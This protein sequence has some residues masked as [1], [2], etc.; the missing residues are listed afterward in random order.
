EL[1]DE[2]KAKGF[3]VT[4]GG[5]EQSHSTGGGDQCNHAM[6]A[7]RPAGDAGWYCMSGDAPSAQG[8]NDKKVRAFLVACRL[9]DAPRPTTAAARFMT[10]SAGDPLIIARRGA[11]FNRRIRMDLRLCNDGPLLLSV[12]WNLTRA[13][14]PGSKPSER[15]IAPDSCI[16]L[17][18]PRSVGVQNG[19]T[20]QGPP[21]SGRYQWFRRDSFDEDGR[22]T[23][24][25]PDVIGGGSGNVA[26]ESGMAECEDVPL[27]WPSRAQFARIC[28]A[29]LEAGSYRLC[30][31][32]EY[33]EAE[34]K[35]NWSATGLVAVLSRRD[36]HRSVPANTPYDPHWNPVIAN[37]CRDLFDID[38]LSFL[39]TN[40]PAEDTWDPVTFKRVLFT[41]QRL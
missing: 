15:Q 18:S 32:K 20:T 25:V 4:G 40:A 13:V 3:A 8:A 27:S 11:D 5:C 39:V 34:G 21:V 1:T 12:Y 23:R 41:I 29:R 22:I 17:L 36:A 28:R 19:T 2:E 37:S 14:E 33:V 35:T 10:T 9:F 7:N 31:G 24:N 38:Y 16:E 6:I 30:F 26:A